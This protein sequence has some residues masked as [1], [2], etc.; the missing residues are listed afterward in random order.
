MTRLTLPLLLCLLAA[1][2]DMPPREAPAC[3]R[4]NPGGSMQCQAATYWYAR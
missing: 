1:C 3:I 2:A 4:G